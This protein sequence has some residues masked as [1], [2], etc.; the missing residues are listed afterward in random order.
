MLAHLTKTLATADFTFAILR[1]PLLKVS[2]YIFL[3]FTR[4]RKS[5]LISPKF[6]QLF[7]HVLMA[8]TGTGGKLTHSDGKLMV[9]H[10]YC[11]RSLAPYTAGSLCKMKREMDTVQ[12]KKMC[13]LFSLNSNFDCFSL[14]ILGNVVILV[15]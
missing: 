4:K 11:S 2:R 5:K 3:S 1:L 10:V 12:K 9:T 14:G 7:S 15:R 13:P 6:F 8:R